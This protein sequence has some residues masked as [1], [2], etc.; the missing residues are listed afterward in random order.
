M[1]SGEFVKLAILSY[2]WRSLFDERPNRINFKGFGRC[3]S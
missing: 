3:D 1:A 2:I